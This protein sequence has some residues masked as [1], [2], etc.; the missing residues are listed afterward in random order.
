MIGFL[1][2][3]FFQIVVVKRRLFGKRFHDGSFK[4][5]WSNA[6]DKRCVDYVCDSGDVFIK[7]SADRDVGI[8]SSE[9][10]FAADLSITFRTCSS[11][12]G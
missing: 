10:V 3:F 11:E 7:H 8:G 2:F 12:S 1:G 9:Q 6:R 5:M 4:L